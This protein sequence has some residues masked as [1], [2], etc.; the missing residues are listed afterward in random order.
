MSFD[1]KKVDSDWSAL[2]MSEAWKVRVSANVR[3]V[4]PRNV[5]FMCSNLRQ[6][7]WRCWCREID[8]HLIDLIDCDWFWWASNF[9]FCPLFYFTVL[10]VCTFASEYKDMMLKMLIKR[11][12]MAKLFQNGCHKL[13]ILCQKPIKCVFDCAASE[14]VW[15]WQ[16]CHEFHWSHLWFVP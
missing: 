14:G 5:F 8:F 10:C 11:W 7:I 9:V 3:C 16:P 13:L 12:G 2:S 6:F 15:T 1:C 4:S